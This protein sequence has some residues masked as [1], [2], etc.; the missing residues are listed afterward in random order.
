[1]SRL[2]RACCAVAE[3]AAGFEADRWSGADCAGSPKSWRRRRTRVPRRAARAAAR[4]VSS[5]RGECGV[6][7]ACHGHNAFAGA[8]DALDGAVRGRVSGDERGAGVR[9]G[10]AR[11]G[12]R[13]RCRRGR[14]A[15]GVGGGVVGGGDHDRDGRLA[16][17]GA[18][19]APRG[20]G[21]RR[22]ARANVG[23][24]GRCSTGSTAWGWSRAGSGCRPRSACR[25]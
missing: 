14:A 22:V 8:D 1:M 25:S 18:A 11:A 17:G 5:Q 24:C 4:A 13:D 2:R 6:V 10:V 19:G 12:A 15:P 9:C 21:S 7:G 16:G 3:E 20:D 23:G